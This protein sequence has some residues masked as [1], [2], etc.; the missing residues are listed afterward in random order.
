MSIIGWGFVKVINRRLLSEPDT[1]T[2]NTRSCLLAFLMLQPHSKDM[3][4]R[5]C[6]KVRYLY[7]CIFGWHTNLHRWSKLATRW[8]CALG[9][10][11]TLEI[12]L[13]CQP[14]EVSFSS[15]WGLFPGVC[16]IIQKDKYRSRANRG[17]QEVAWAK[18]S[19]RHP[20]LFRLCQL[21]SAIIPGLQ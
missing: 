16:N 14:E 6:W 17:C 15:G 9:S 1:A 2:S 11:L 20:S 3:L 21:L 12:L 13:L 7:Y 5:F 8:G 18:V 10:R 4:T 19:T